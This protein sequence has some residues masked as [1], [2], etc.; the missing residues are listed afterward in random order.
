MP[1]YVMLAHF[2]EQGVKNAKDTVKRA[3]AF[4]QSAKNHG[5]TVKEQ[6]WTLGQFDI[7]A[8]VDAPDEA[9]M[10]ALGLSAGAL[11]NVRTQ[12]LR[13]FTEAEMNTIL[14]KMA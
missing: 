5:A 8:I 13:A 12:T 6:F 10:T 9:T 4:R 1:T 3:E 2:T 14:G 11:G 7:V